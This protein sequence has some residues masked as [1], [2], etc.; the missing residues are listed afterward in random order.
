MFSKIIKNKYT[1]YVLAGAIAA[2]LVFVYANY[3]TEAA[4]PS[5]ATAGN[6]SQ[7]NN[8]TSTPAGNGAFY[9]NSTINFK[10]TT[11]D[12][13]KNSLAMYFNLASTSGTLLSATTTPAN[14]CQTYTAYASCAS[15]VWM[16]STASTSTWYRPDFPYRAKFI[17]Q[18]AGVGGSLTNFPIYLDLARFGGANGFWSHTKRNSDGGDIVI[19]NSTG[20]RLPVEVV[21]LSTSTRAGEVWFRADAIS[22]TSPIT[23]Y[24][25]YG[26]STASQPASSTTYGARSVWSNSYLAVYHLATDNFKDSTGNYNG[27]N[28]GTTNTT[29]KLGV[30]KNF[31]GT[32]QAISLADIDVTTGATYSAWVNHGTLVNYAKIIAKTQTTA[33]APYTIFNLGVDASANKLGHA[34]MASAG[35]AYHAYTT[36]VLPTTF[37]YVAGTFDGQNLRAYYNGAVQ[38]TTPRVGTIDTN[39][40]PTQI[41][42]SYF[43]GATTE[44]WTGVIDEARIAS[45]ARSGKWLLTE[46]NNQNS[47][48]TFFGTTTEQTFASPHKFVKI[49]GVPDNGYKWQVLGCDWEGC[50]TNWTAFNGTTPNFTVDTTKPTNPATLTLSKKNDSSITLNLGATSTDTNFY[51][52]KIYYKAGSSG[53]AETDTAFGSS[54]SPGDATFTNSN[55]SRHTTTTITGLAAN[56]AYVF[57]IWAYDKA[58]NKASSSGEYST[59]TKNFPAIA[60]GLNQYKADGTT[61]ITNDTWVMQDEIYLTAT[62]T[63]PDSDAITLYYQLATT[64]GTYLTA[65]TTPAGACSSGTTYAACPAR[66]WQTLSQT[67]KVDLKTVA[68][69]QYKW[70]VLAC[71]ADGCARN[72]KTFNDTVPNI[73]I[74]TLAPSAPNPLT[75]LASTTV[76]IK[77]G[78]PAAVTE[79]NFYQYKIFY[80]LGST[81]PIHETDSLWGSSSD[82]NLSSRTFNGKSSTT[83]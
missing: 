30:A 66:V 82:A 2:L 49:T 68:D 1:K 25:Y 35:T 15:K 70:Q 77:L 13:D 83:V 58:G 59:A 73:K 12:P 11:T 55:F 17:V 50:S 78:F 18:T 46:Y 67:K 23:F 53:V 64:S 26:S 24:M 3:V 8:S 16:N 52:Y 71:D 27:T 7:Y 31:S 39:N 57:R 32:A 63:D 21:S 29:G 9:N 42:R 51:Q 62:S 56:T 80:R 6:L 74:D 72:W 5:T 10:A 28:V 22:S 65:T 34:E 47:P 37:S 41:G 61:V 69:G 48:G 79:G 33:V 44:Y 81:T 76:S 38:G 40:D 45:V 43:G 36:T 14:P 20:T 54:T 60:S 75:R 4:R 19:T